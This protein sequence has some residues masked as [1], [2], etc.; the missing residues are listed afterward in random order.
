MRFRSCCSTSTAEDP[1]KI[2]GRYA[3]DIGGRM[4]SKSLAMGSMCNMHCPLCH[5]VIF[6]EPPTPV[7]SVCMKAQ[8]GIALRQGIGT[9]QD[10]Y[11]HFG[12]S[13]WLPVPIIRY[14]QLQAPSSVVSYFL[15]NVLHKRS[16]IVF[17]SNPV[18]P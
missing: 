14:R 18:V 10:S 16:V 7:L 15:H 17:L 2:C 1:R 12:E 13:D 3:E 6:P 5:T 4:N 11:E 8:H 9:S